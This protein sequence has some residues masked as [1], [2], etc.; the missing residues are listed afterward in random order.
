VVCVGETIAEPE[1]DGVTVPTLL[2]L[3]DVAL[4]LA[5]ESVVLC[6]LDNEDDVTE[7]VQVGAAVVTP[8]P[9]WPKPVERK[10]NTP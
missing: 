8:P 3:P 4:V 2:M 7:S 5:Q 10:L 6:P 9:G 1:A